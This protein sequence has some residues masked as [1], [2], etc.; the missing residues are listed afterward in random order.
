MRY[1]L[2]GTQEDT[3]ANEKLLT[4]VP[5]QIRQG[6]FTREI[7]CLVIGPGSEPDD[8]RQDG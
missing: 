7:P 5:A 2:P 3:S 4:V 6:A 8:Q 1:A